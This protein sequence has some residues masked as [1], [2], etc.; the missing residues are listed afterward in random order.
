MAISL[1]KWTSTHAHT[2]THTQRHI[3]RQIYIDTPTHTHTHTPHPLEN[4]P[5]VEFIYLV[6]TRMPGEVTT[7]NSGLCC[8][9]PWALNSLCL[10]ILLTF[11]KMSWGSPG[12]VGLQSRMTLGSLQRVNTWVTVDPPTGAPVSQSWKIKQLQRK[13]S[14]H[15]HHTL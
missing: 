8:G 11:R 6:F 2:Q 7:G 14:R 5:L 1:Q 4:L 12:W 15:R 9:V 3:Y 13:N 10:W